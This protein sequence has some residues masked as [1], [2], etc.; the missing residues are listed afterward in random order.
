MLNTLCTASKRQR[1]RTSDAHIDFETIQAGK[2][3]QPAYTILPLRV[4]SSS[5]LSVSSI[6]VSSSHEWQ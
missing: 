4:R 6:G 3:E 5:A 1:F 2:F